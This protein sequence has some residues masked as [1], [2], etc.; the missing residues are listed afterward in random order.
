MAFRLLGVVAADAAGAADAADAAV[1]P[2]VAAGAVAVPAALRGVGA[3]G[4]EPGSFLIK[5]T[6]AVP[7]GRVRQ[8]RPGFSLSYLHCETASMQRQARA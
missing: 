5:L 8:C 6:E 1:G 7:Y 4:A 2:A 3:A